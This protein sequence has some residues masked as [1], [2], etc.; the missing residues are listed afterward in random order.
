MLNF[1]EKK[2]A[3]PVLTEEQFVRVKGALQVAK[4]KKVDLLWLQTGFRNKYYLFKQYGF[5]GINMYTLLN[6]NTANSAGAAI[7][8]TGAVAFSVPIM[9]GLSWCGGL[10]LSTL[11]NVIPDNMVKTKAV[12]QGSKF[13]IGIPIRIVETTTNG[14]LGFAE[15]RII[16]DQLPINVTADFRLTQGPKIED[17]PKLRKSLKNFLTWLINKI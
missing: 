5:N 14:I 13:V 1:F 12:V 4:E 3:Q 11:E 8:A 17:L 10:F 9:I 16:G 2:A 15:R 7:S 6:L